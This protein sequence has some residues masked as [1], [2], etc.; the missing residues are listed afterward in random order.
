[1]TEPGC[2]GFSPQLDE[3]LGHRVYQ[4]QTVD[5]VLQDVAVRLTPD[6]ASAWSAPPAFGDY[7]FE[8][9]RSRRLLLTAIVD[10][11]AILTNP[12]SYDRL[13]QIA[14]FTA[15]IEH[16]FPSPDWPAAKGF[17]SS[18]DDFA[19]GGSEEQV[20]AK[21]SDWCAEVARVYCGLTQVCGIP[22]RIVYTYSRDDGH[23]ISECF[24]DSE[25]VLVDPLS[26][27][28]YRDSAGEPVSSV[29]MALAGREERA[30]LTQS[31]EGYYVDAAFFECVCVAEYRLCNAT[32]YSYAL[33]PCNDY[34][35][36]L[37]SPMWNR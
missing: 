10:R 20:I 31:H 18:P 14:N 3:L 6:T 32:Q 30:R 17:Y 22:S 21:G 8:Q 37:L 28:V 27:K 13:Q 4:P 34:Y 19:W 35:Y 25:W 24:V 7:Q 26:S 11:L 12:N 23:V 36:R 15:S 5:A 33:S 1:M 2:W 16:K 9:L 29:R